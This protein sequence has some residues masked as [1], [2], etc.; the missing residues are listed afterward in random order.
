MTTDKQLYILQELDLALE[1]LQE[2]K[3]EAEEELSSGLSIDHVETAFQEEEE[4]LLEVQSQHNLQQL[5]V[6]TLRERSTRL[7][8]Q[9]YS[10]EISNPRDL[11]SL[12]QEVNQ[13]RGLLEQQDAELLELSVQAEESRNRRDSLQREISDS[14]AAWEAR[15]AELEGQVE[16][17]KSEVET[18]STQRK[19]LADTLDPSAVQRYEGLRRAKRGLAVAKVERGLCQACRMALPTQQQQR[20]RIGRQTVLCS[21]CGRILILS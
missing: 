10:G 20:V 1:R 3:T 14:R 18:V 7:E 13:V 12:E 15:Q 11:E 19:D 16:S 4:R 8:A 9:L 5:E 21:S 2:V 17:W 6:G